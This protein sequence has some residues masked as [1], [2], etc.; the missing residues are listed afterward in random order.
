MALAVVRTPYLLFRCMRCVQCGKQ[1]LPVMKQRGHNANT[2]I[3]PNTNPNTNTNKHHHHHHHHQQQQQQQQ[4]HAE[5]QRVVMRLKM[6][7]RG[8][9]RVLSRARRAVCRRC[10]L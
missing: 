6:R 9:C 1:Q 2:N 5:E 4:Q 7:L 10:V 3:S 8:L